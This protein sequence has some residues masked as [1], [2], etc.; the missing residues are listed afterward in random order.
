[1]WNCAAAFTN[2]LVVLQT[3]KHNYS[4]AQQFHTK[5]SVYTRELKAS[6]H[7]YLY[8]HIHSNIICNS[9]RIEKLKYS[10][11]GEW[12]L[13]VWFITQWNIIQHW[14]LIRKRWGNH[15]SLCSQD[16]DWVEKEMDWHPLKVETLLQVASAFCPLQH[17]ATLL[18]LASQFFCGRL[19]LPHSQFKY[20]DPM[21]NSAPSI[22][23]FSSP[24]PQW[25]VQK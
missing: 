18:D 2:S 9:Q 7:R 14:S 25:L 10:S 20:Q 15:L 13:K 1:M 4:V 19:S 21:A 11:T 3:V 17:P 24:W 22:R 23:T 6:T 12:I 5:Y 8:T 16:S